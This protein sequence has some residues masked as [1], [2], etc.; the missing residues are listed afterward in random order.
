MSKVEF[1]SRIKPTQSAFGN[2]SYTKIFK[3]QAHSGKIKSI[4]R[5]E[6]FDFVS[7]TPADYVLVK[8]N[9]SKKVKLLLN[10]N[11]VLK[12]DLQCDIISNKLY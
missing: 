8:A 4:K 2:L 7:I 5:N 10:Y 1:W 6:L 9:I 12:K 3:N 11:T